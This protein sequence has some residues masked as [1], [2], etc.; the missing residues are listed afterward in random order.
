MRTSQLLE[1]QLALMHNKVPHVLVTLIGVRGS[2]PQDI[3]AKMLIGENGLL[4]GTVGG[5][6]VEALVIVTAQQMLSQQETHRHCTWNLQK[7]VKMTCGGEVQFFFEAFWSSSWNIVVFGA[8]HVAQTL[9][10]LLCQ[11]E[12]Q[13][14]CIDNRP[15]WIAKLPTLSN[16]KAHCLE[17]PASF[18]P[19]LPSNCTIAVM[20]KGHHSDIP[21]LAALAQS[22][23]SHPYIGMIGSAV[24]A[25]KVRRELREM[26]VSNEWLA[27]FRSP[28]GLPIG[29]NHPMEIAISIAAE[30]LQVR[31]RE[32][33]SQRS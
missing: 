11:L 31:G 12:A 19:S 13:V 16:L 18:V 26:G 17:E 3:G 33:S 27:Q 9:V 1:Q 28:I 23:Q 20:T 5:G 32:K 2:A 30:M 24:K 22:G 25:G 8:G 29:N 21:I 14:Q 7:D 6:K 15:E 4:G 10:P